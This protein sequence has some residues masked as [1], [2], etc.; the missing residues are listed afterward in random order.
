MFQIP[1]WCE[2]ELKIRAESEESARELEKF[3]K[4]AKGK[5]RYD[6]F[7]ILNEENFI[8]YPKKY[9]DLDKKAKDWIENN[10]NKD[11]TSRFS[12][13]F[14][15]GFNTGGYDWC[16]ENWGTKWGICHAVIHKDKI[17][18]DWGE[19]GYAFDCAWSPPEPLVK[20]MAKMFPMLKFELKFWE[21]ANCFK[22][23]L[24]C[25]NGKT[26]KQETTKYHGKRGG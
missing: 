20:T 6:K 14:K 4:F 23:I 10:K 11:G 16:V 3:V 15:D 18:R 17:C 5:N 26:I 2:C 8:P 22:G 12:A 19:V 1:N 7:K 21:G 9:A 25:E 24:I 13:P